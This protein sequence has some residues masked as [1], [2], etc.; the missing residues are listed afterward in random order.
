MSF[1]WESIDGRFLLFLYNVL[2]LYKSSDFGGILCRHADDVD[3]GG[4]VGCI[5][6][7]RFVMARHA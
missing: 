6:F 7:Q 1:L 3:A 2:F 4:Q 5:D